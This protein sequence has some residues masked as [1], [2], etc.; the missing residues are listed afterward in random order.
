MIAVTCRNGEHFTID[1]AEIERVM[2]EHPQ[3]QDV[4]VIGVP[5]ERWGE[6]PK[7]VV[8]AKPG[9]TIDTEQLLDWC[10]QQI[11]SFK[12]PKTVDVVAEHRDGWLSVTVD[13]DGPGI[14]AAEREAV[15][16]PFHRL[17]A[18]RKA[19]LHG[20]FP[21]DSSECPVRLW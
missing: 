16:R 9:T 4:A 12:C 11:A 7:A 17:D 21:W 19:G 1:P 14:P 13:D 15:F 6:V 5:D 18:A 8:V 2:A 20:Q 10:R 3:I